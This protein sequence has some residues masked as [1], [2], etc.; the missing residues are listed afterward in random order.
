MTINRLLVG[1]LG[2][3]ALA[4]IALAGD[5]V[6]HRLGVGIPGPVLG[7]AAYVAAL[8]LAPS[9]LRWTLP[10]ARMLTGLLGALIVPAAVGLLLFLPLLAAGALPLAIVLLVSTLVT[11]LATALLMQALRRHG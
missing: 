10:A 3:A 11:G 1:A 4:A 5:F 9:A 8:L 6:A 7:L 2:L